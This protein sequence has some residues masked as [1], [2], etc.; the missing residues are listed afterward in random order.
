MNTFRV[1][2]YATLLVFAN[3]TAANTTISL[4]GSRTALQSENVAANRLRLTRISDDTKLRSFRKKG[5]LVPLP[6]SK[7][8]KVDHRIPYKNR[9]CRPWTRQFLIQLSSHF[10]ARFKEPLM[11]TSAVRTVGY[12]HRLMRINPNAAR[13]DTPLRRSSHL[14][15]ATI[16]ISKKNMTVAE[17][18]WIRDR[19]ILNKQVGRALVTEEFGQPVFHIMVLR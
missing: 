8:L 14:T 5:L 17:K 3:T 16:D 10:F 18:H 1:V 15:G 12:Q 6:E 7:S 2:A 4:R 11:V 13:G 19:L 9:W